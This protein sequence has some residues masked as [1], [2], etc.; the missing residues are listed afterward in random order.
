[1]AKSPMR[2]GLLPPLAHPKKA[3]D[4]NSRWG[5]AWGALVFSCWKS[6][7]V[8]ETAIFLGKTWKVPGFWTNI[9]GVQVCKMYPASFRAIPLGERR[10]WMIFGAEREPSQPGVGSSMRIHMSR[11]ETAGASQRHGTMIGITR[12]NIT[13]ILTWRGYCQ[14]R[15]YKTIKKQ[16]WLFEA[17]LS[18]GIQ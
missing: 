11:L 5:F 9:S 15:I 1:M 10:W 18:K 2:L 17:G 16:S 6:W 13:G 7:K 12:G 3:S 4:G 14:P 8:I